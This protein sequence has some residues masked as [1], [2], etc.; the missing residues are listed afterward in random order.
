[1]TLADQV[2]IGR[3]AQDDGMILV[4]GELDAEP[5]ADYLQEGWTPEQDIANNPLSVPSI[6]D[7]S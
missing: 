2:T 4:V 1:M 5:V 3:T 7:E 6:E